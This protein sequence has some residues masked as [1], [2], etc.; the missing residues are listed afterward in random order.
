[1]GVLSACAMG[2]AD[3]NVRVNGEHKILPLKRILSISR[4]VYL[5]WRTP[6]SVMGG[7]ALG[8]S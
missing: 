5:A 3:I 1:M 6:N 7:S 8:R 2:C 4:A